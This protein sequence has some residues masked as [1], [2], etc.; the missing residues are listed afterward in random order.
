[1]LWNL[2]AIRKVNGPGGLALSVMG[3]YQQLTAS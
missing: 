2:R 3:I 1:M